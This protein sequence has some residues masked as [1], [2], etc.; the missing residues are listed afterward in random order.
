MTAIAATTP[1]RTT[2]SPECRL[3][4]SNATNAASS[5]SHPADAAT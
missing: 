5:P 4:T 1:A 2:G 3:I